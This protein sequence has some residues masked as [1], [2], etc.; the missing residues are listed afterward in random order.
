MSVYFKIF[1]KTILIHVS[2]T[3]T[4]YFIH[5]EWWTFPQVYYME[6]NPFFLLGRRLW[7]VH[8]DCECC[9]TVSGTCSCTGHSAIGWSR[10]ERKQL[11][12]LCQQGWSLISTTQWTLLAFTHSELSSHMF[13]EGKKYLL[14]KMIIMYQQSF[15]KCI[16]LLLAIMMI[17]MEAPL[18]TQLTYLCSY[19][20]FPIHAFGPYL[21]KS[22]KQEN[23][24]NTQIDQLLALWQIP[25]VFKGIKSRS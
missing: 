11:Y 1:F 25:I 9:C 8:C 20:I 3:E 15:K 23:N 17:M 10:S 19:C 13:S 16:S 2:Q 4:V 22:A 7:W 6:T 14:L 5:T 21:H 24:W 18:W 12:S